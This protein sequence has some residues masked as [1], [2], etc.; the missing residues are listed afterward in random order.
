[1]ER[2]LEGVPSSRYEFLGSLT[3]MQRAPIVGSAVATLMPTGF[4]EPFGGSGVEGLLTGTPLL[5]SDWGAFTE[6]VQYGV[7]G[8]R[9]KTLGDWLAAIKE[10]L[11]RARACPQDLT[12]TLKNREEIAQ[13][14]RARYSLE[15]CADKYDRAFRQL[16][17]LAGKGWYEDTAFQV[18]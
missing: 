5:A 16:A 9:C 12:G 13:A 10:C 8:W 14:A 4:V 6:T 3:G 17:A 7:N 11:E 15:A 2:A 1:M 18:P